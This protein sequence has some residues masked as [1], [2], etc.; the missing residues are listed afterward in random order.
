MR[1]ESDSSFFVKVWEA[2]DLAATLPLEEFTIFIHEMLLEQRGLPRY[3]SRYVCVSVRTLDGTFQA[4]TVHQKR[5]LGPER[6]VYY[7][8]KFVSRFKIYSWFT[9][10]EY[11]TMCL[12]I[13]LCI[14]LDLDG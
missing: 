7:G 11:E 3:V 8:D 10:H 13:F 1:R 5:N 12:T 2:C 9:F 14:S 6:T 4:G